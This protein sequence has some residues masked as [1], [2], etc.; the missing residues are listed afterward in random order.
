MHNLTILVNAEEYTR[1]LATSGI[2]HSLKSQML[3]WLHITAVMAVFLLL[4]CIALMILL[5][6]EVRENKGL[7]SVIDQMHREDAI[8]QK[9]PDT[10]KEAYR[11]VKF[12]SHTE[13]GRG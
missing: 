12:E 9:F 7:H 2:Y 5:L 6:H 4:A 3:P 10:E 1:L 13:R 8:T 11:D